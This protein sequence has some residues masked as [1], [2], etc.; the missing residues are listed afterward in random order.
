[1]SGPEGARSRKGS[2]GTFGVEE[3]LERELED[4][5][6]RRHRHGFPPPRREPGGDLDDAG[7]VG[8]ALSGGGIRSATFNLG[9]IQAL[10]ARGALARVDYLSTVSGGG[11]IGANLVNQLSCWSE[12]L[13][14]EAVDGAGPLALDVSVAESQTRERS[15]ARAPLT[16]EL[17]ASGPVAAGRRFRICVPGN[18]LED[19]PPCHAAVI[20][21]E[22]PLRRVEDD[23]GCLEVD[24]ALAEGES[25]R[26][27]GDVVS[28]LRESFPLVHEQGRR[29]GRA[30]RHLRRFANYLVPDRLMAS[31]RLPGVFVAGVV[32][33]IVMLLPFLMLATVLAFFLWGE[34][35]KRALTVYSYEVPVKVE[36][37][38]GRSAI[39]LDLSALVPE[40][41]R[42]GGADDSR[43]EL[44]NGWAVRI[45][46]LPA[47]ITPESATGA[48]VEFEPYLGRPDSAI[49]FVSAGRPGMEVP[50]TLKI[51]LDTALIQDGFRFEVHAWRHRWVSEGVAQ[52][53]G[54]AA[55]DHTFG[56]SVR[57]RLLGLFCAGRSGGCGVMTVTGHPTDPLAALHIASALTLGGAAAVV[58]LVMALFPAAELIVRRRFGS[59]WE[60]RDWATRWVIG[61]LLLLLVVFAAIEV[62]PLLTYHMARL[63]MASAGEGMLAGRIDMITL[64]TALSTIAGGVAAVGRSESALVGRVKSV[65]LLGLA[66]LSV[67]L[68]ATYLTTWHLDGGS[69]ALLEVGS[70]CAEGSRAHASAGPTSAV[71]D[72]TPDHVERPAPDL[73]LQPYWFWQ[74]SCLM[75][76]DSRAMRQAPVADAAAK[77]DVAGFLGTAL[78]FL[79]GVPVAITPQ[80]SVTTFLLVALALWFVTRRYYDVNLTSLHAFYRDRLSR[81]YLYDPYVAREGVRT[82]RHT[83]DVA[84][85]QLDPLHAPCLLVNA[86]LNVPRTRDPTSRA[87]RAEF[88]LFSR[89]ASGSGLTGFVATETLEARETG[90]GLASA[91]AISGA[92]VSPNM[93]THTSRGGALALTLFNARL[94]YWL[95]NPGKQRRA[96]SFGHVGPRHL[97][98]E[99][100]ALLDEN[101]PYV[102]VSDGG[103]LENLGIHELVRRRCR[104]IVCGDAEMDADMTFGG[105]ADAIRMVQI[106]MGIKIEIDLEPLRRGDDGLSDQHYALGR[107]HYSEDFVGD[108]VYLK[109]ST[110]HEQETHE[111]TYRSRHPTFPHEATSDQDF[112]ED[113]FEAYR[114]LGY[115]VANSALRDD[116][117]LP[118]SHQTLSRLLASE[119]GDG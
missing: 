24:R 103:H 45:V 112:Q 84:L 117:K 76:P 82:L 118:G 89:R 16:L 63:R 14:V 100:L 42:L 105:L 43:A 102:N 15:G 116:P 109:S 119:P 44:Q 10:H 29:E 73:Y 51:D 92:A 6:S 91:V 64:F 95:F 33:N 106:D 41:P 65:L 75:E 62:Q 49:A 53:Q 87:R 13:E 77:D 96:M 74:L 70:V 110:T 19:E 66:P 67:W 83:S 18:C 115:K 80:G 46:D 9:V 68:L 3:V 93:G 114:A 104:L 61:G 2:V 107:I 99:A 27:Q 50:K 54:I 78:A 32:A 5:A 22:A 108:L 4:V 58:M 71:G 31:M 21:A 8:L 94:G 7:L 85:T 88:F 12:H 59:A 97:L 79:R 56:E 111:R 17:R 40:D 81:A 28:P 30:I 23:H 38:R 98:A 11:F 86:T 47:G 35:I 25:A 55:G 20:A 60:S 90:F 52:R 36:D 113:Q 34:E 72:A 57:H 101:S 69:R 39:R 1:M 26:V 37:V 48:P